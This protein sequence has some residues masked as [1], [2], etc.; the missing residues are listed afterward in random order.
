MS[1][2]NVRVDAFVNAS[3]QFIDMWKR[4][5]PTRPK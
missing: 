2:G 5:E 1:E 3:V 4:L